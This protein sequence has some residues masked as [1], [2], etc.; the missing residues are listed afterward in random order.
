M[1]LFYI[2]LENSSG[3]KT[4][5]EDE[6]YAYINDAV[7]RAADNGDNIV[8]VTIRTSHDPSIEENETSPI[9]EKQMTPEEIREQEKD[10]ALARQ[11]ETVAT[12][13]DSLDS[14]PRKLAI[15]TRIKSITPIP[16]ADRI[17]AI[18]FTQ[19]H[20][21]CV[22]GK[23]EFREGQ[24]CVFWEIDSFLKKDERYDDILSKCLRVMKGQEG[25]RIRSQ[26]FRQ[27]ISQGYAMPLSKFPELDQN[28]E[29]GTDVTELLGVRLWQLPIAEG[30]GFCI[31]R[32][33]GGFPH[34]IRKTDQ[35]RIQSLGKRKIMEFFGHIGFVQEVKMD[36]TS[37]TMGY[38]Y[39]NDEYKFCVCSRNLELKPPGKE[40]ITYSKMTEYDNGG[41]VV[42]PGEGAYMKEE[43][44]TKEVEV[45]SVYWDM[46]RKYHIEKRLG[47]YCKENERQLAIQGEI[48]GPGI[49]GNRQKLDEINFYVFDIFDIVTQ[50]YVDV[51]E[52]KV[53]IAE[54]NSDAELPNITPVPEIDIKNVAPTCDQLTEALGIT[55]THRINRMRE[56]GVDNAP[57]QQWNMFLDA[58]VD[59]IVKDLLKQANTITVNGQQAEGIV[60]KSLINPMVSF[61]V[62]S[63]TYLLKER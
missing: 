53:I 61:K 37:C 26:K 45:N 21:T 41:N 28:A 18:T 34:F 23:G 3:I 63:N 43:V 5:S 59:I 16:E 24:P 17:E 40:I 19:N 33:K 13:E 47:N 15:I 7:L 12:E 6:F 9:H 29:D 54:M 57:Y 2:D 4:D 8:E 1:P 56:T 36:G 48:C 51:S 11:Q 25:Y 60:M 49:N 27:Q 62:V 55:N 20:W 52:R 30:F 32:P 10:E 14:S 22:A 50:R 31:G 44:C 46:A 38:Y 58:L 39:Q 42:P 35:Q